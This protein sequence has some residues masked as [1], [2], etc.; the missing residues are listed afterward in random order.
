[1]SKD[2]AH[3]IKRMAVSPFS[4]PKFTPQLQEQVWK[5]I[6]ESN[7]QSRGGVSGMKVLW[8]GAALCLFI[9]G[10]SFA[11][12]ALSPEWKGSQRQGHSVA[13]DWK[14]RQEYRKDGKSLFSVFPGGDRI[15]GKNDRVLWIFERP[16]EEW[17]GSELSVKA[18]HRDTGE[19]RLVVPSMNVNE[20]VRGTEAQ[21]GIATR[22]GLPYAGLWRLEV[23]VNDQYYGDAVIELEEHA[24][25]VSDEFNY[26]SY[27]LR[28]IEGRLGILVPGFIAGKGN[29]TMWYM[30]GSKEE[31]NGSPKVIAI[32]QGTGR[33]ETIIEAL[34]EVYGDAVKM[35]SMV[36]LP[37]PGLWRLTVLLGDQVFDSIVVE[38][39]EN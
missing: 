19:E 16:L 1:M 23:T 35:P 13:E 29:K 6:H 12:I 14:I 31:L 20:S 26:E 32:S 28:G 22:F 33:I 5:R 15:A 24:W 27:M 25:T 37:E 17:K 10:G 18:V 34:P 3:W 11:Y 39:K 9:L 2:Q 30:W 4:T 21:T 7:C 38:V 8:A 36:M